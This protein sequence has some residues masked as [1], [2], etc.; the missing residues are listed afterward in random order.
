MTSE[1]FRTF[2]TFVAAMFVSG[3][4]LTAATNAPLV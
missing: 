1:A 2:S 3:M 4:L